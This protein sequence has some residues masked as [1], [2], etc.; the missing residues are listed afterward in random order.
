MLKALKKFVAQSYPITWV[1]HQARLTLLASRPGDPV[2]IFQMGKVGSTAILA[3]LEAAAPTKPVFHVHF[4]SDQGLADARKRLASLHADNR[5]A[6]TWCLLESQFLR[7]KLARAASGRWKVISLVRDPVARNISSFFFNIQRYRPDLFRDILAGQENIHSIID[8][9]LNEFP[10]HDYSLE[11]FDTEMKCVFGVDVYAVPFQAEK[12]FRIY[13]S[14]YID[15]LLLRLESLQVCAQDAFREFMGLTEFRVL[16]ANSADELIYADAYRRF[17]RAVAI[18]SMYLDRMYGAQYTRHFYTY[19]EI[20]NFR[21]RWS[22]ASSAA[23]Q[24]KNE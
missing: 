10:E 21:A 6:N 11:W 18:P 9:F 23:T 7:R 3:S 13:R 17:L 14:E 20:E 22:R 5:N 16:M 4:L 8:V 12:G 24:P 19:E 1:Y 15:L 2:I